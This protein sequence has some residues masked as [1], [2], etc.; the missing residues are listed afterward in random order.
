MRSLGQKPTESELQDMISQVEAEGNGTIDFELFLSFMARQPHFDHRKMKDTETDN[1][2]Q[3]A[4]KL[5]NRGGKGLISSDD[6]RT[7]MVSMGEK[8]REE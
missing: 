2:L 7:V 4:F 8:L 1:E 5:F 3:S 6:L